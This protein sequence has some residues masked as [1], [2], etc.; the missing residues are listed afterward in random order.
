MIANVAAPVP[1]AAV[2]A[3]EAVRDL[4][5]RTHVRAVVIAAGQQSRAGRRPQNAVVWNWL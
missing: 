1:R 2:I 3:R 4:S 5:D